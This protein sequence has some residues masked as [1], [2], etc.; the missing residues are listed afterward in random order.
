WLRLPPAAGPFFF[1][2]SM[3]LRYA[4]LTTAGPVRPVNEDWLYFWES[5]DPLAREKQGSVA[6]IA[7]GVGGY[8]HGEVASRL[9]VETAIQEF[10]SAPADTKPYTLLRK[11]F[12]SACT[13]VHEKVVTGHH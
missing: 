8:E 1:A 3:R 13:A 10:Q 5:P 6:L 11:M 7:D 12:T 4:R 2:R 9:A